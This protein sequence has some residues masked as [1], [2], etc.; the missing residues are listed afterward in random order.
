[1]R[2]SPLNTQKLFQRT[3]E[4]GINYNPRCLKISPFK[5]FQKETNYPGNLGPINSCQVNQQNMS[6]TIISIHTFGMKTHPFG[7]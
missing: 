7:D 2:N 3:P 5:E 6:I 4:T 1:M